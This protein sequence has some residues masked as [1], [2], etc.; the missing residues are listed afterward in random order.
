MTAARARTLHCRW[1]TPNREIPWI[2]GDAENG[3]A[4]P[5]RDIKA[6]T[7]RKIS[8]DHRER[9]AAMVARARYHARR[10]LL[11]RKFRD[12]GR[13]VS[14]AFMS[15]TRGN[16]LC[17]SRSNRDEF[18]SSTWRTGGTSARDALSIVR[19]IATRDKYKSICIKINVKS[20]GIKSDTI[21]ST[22]RFLSACIY[23]VPKSLLIIKKKET[24]NAW[25]DT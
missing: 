10:T 20:I 15:L 11:G 5:R 17:P 8:L 4:M 23:T 24:T 6:Y 12:K 3:S 7:Y 1:R 14:V 2:F 18:M 9:S 25:T 21:V 13:L 16:G 19:R 22:R